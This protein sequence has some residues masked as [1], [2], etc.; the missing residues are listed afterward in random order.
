MTIEIHHGFVNNKLPTNLKLDS[1]CS[2]AKCRK[3]NGMKV[4]KFTKNR[5]IRYK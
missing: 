2:F 1:I 4:A 5:N 3:Y